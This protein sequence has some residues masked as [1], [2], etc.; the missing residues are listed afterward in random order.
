MPWNWSFAAGRAARLVGKAAMP[1]AAVCALTLAACDQ[2][3]PADVAAAQPRGATV[4]FESIDG[5]PDAKFRRLVADLNDAAQAR[6]LAVLSR[7]QPSAYRVRGYLAAGVEQGATTINWV[8]DV[9]DGQEHRMLRIAGEERAQA[10]PHDGW[11]AADDALLHRIATASMD[12]LAAFLTSTAALPATATPAGEP[13]L[14]FGSDRSSPEAA[15]IFRIVQP[16]AD[17]VAGGNA[18]APAA[19]AAELSAAPAPQAPPEAI[20]A[21]ETLML[22]ASPRR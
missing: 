5:L 16:Q 10:A 19:P 3:G 13:Q 8:W 15:G 22:A 7:E 11:A 17:P 20:S 1:I 12:Q 6:R 2:N 4:A 9:F 21:H 14:A 18:Q